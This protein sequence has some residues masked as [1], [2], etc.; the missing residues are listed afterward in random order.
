MPL[1]VDEK[2]ITAVTTL[3]DRLRTEIGPLRSGQNDSGHGN[4][5]SPTQTLDGLLIK[6]GGDA[7]QLGTQLEQR[8]STQAKSLSDQL[9]NRAMYIS[10]FVA[11]MRVFLQETDDTENYNTITADKFIPYLPKI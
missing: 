9:T 5:F 10:Q 1:V 6:A 3:L 2:Y 11:N 8:L 7:Y 4:N